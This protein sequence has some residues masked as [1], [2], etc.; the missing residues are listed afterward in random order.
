MAGRASIFRQTRGRITRALAEASQAV[1]R[2]KFLW[3]LVLAAALLY[4]SLSI[5]RHR[6]FASSA[7]DLGIFDQ[8]IWEYSRFQAPYSSVRS[9]LLT[10]NLLRDHFHPAL[11]L[12]A[13]LYWLTDSVEALL[14]AQALLLAI[15]AVPI[16]LFTEKRLGKAA[17]YL[18]AVSYSLFWG[19]QRAVEFDFHEI[20]LAVP[21]IALAIHFMDGRRWR[22]Y[23][24]CVA[25]LLLTKENLSVTVVFFGVYLVVTRQFRQGLISIAAGAI[26]FF[27]AVKIFIPFFVGPDAVRSDAPGVS[28]RYWSYHQFGTGPLS[29]LKTVI[30]NPPFVVK[31]LLSPAVKLHTYW[32][33][34]H[35]FL[36]LPFF[37]PL[38]ILA[39]PL[40]AERFLSEGPQFW[41]MD[42]H[43]TATLAPVLVMA[44]A[45][46]LARIARRIKKP[47]PSYLIVPAA[48]L[49]LAVNLYLLPRFPLWNLSSPAYWRL[50]ASDMTGR[51][52]V[53]LIPPEASVAA[54][55]PVV[56]HLSHRRAIYVLNPLT[57]IP[58]SD[59]VVASDRV[60]PDPFRSFGEIKYYLDAQQARGYRKVFEEEGWVILKRETLTGT[61]VPIYND[62]A[63]V[64]QSVPA[65][66]TA[67]Q[68]YD[69][70]VRLRNAGV[71]SWTPGD[72]YRLA[73]LGKTPDWGRERV[74]MPSVVTAG[75]TA[76]FDFKVTAPAAPG[77]YSFR[78]RMV[79]DGVAFFGETAPEVLIIVSARASPRE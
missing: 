78:C 20:A 26:W 76:T 28:Y 47:K 49:F 16:F 39:V 48:I 29:A 24:V 50:S 62:A 64:E 25:L 67:G 34:F 14:A 43:Y 63:F 72:S 79:Q 52:A 70:R 30:T 21:L 27:A 12:L 5:L 68:S 59:Y 10:E 7:Y 73:L 4:S 45:D 56:P 38:F 42:F 31:T 54:Q 60:S 2:R 35:P 44:S 1:R 13:P 36:F 75:S 17:G 32:Y 53:S 3:L 6:H 41:G 33:I 22:A 9:N 55:G 61:P 71:N 40:I 58:D 15:A 66:M 69:V 8:V 74:E 19:I 23:F 46:G 77:T 18:F 65:S 57:V 11:A 51:R 37:S